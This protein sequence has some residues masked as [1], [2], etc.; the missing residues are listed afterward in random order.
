VEFY[1]AQAI[2][3]IVVVFSHKPPGKDIVIKGAQMTVVPTVD[4][5]NSPFSNPAPDKKLVIG[6]PQEGRATVNNSQT[7]PTKNENTKKEK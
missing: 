4:H 7:T 1:L 5:D 2:L 6:A 3:V